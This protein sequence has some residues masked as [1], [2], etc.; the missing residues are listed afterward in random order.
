MIVS[1]RRKIAE[2]TFNGCLSIGQSLFKHGVSCAEKVSSGTG[3]LINPVG[4]QDCDTESVFR[5]VEGNRQALVRLDIKQDCSY[6]RWPRKSGGLCLEFLAMAMKKPKP[7]CV[8]VSQITEGGLDWTMAIPDDVVADLLTVQFVSGDE[9]L[10]IEVR[11]ALAGNNVLANGRVT[12][13]LRS[14]CGRCLAE[15]EFVVNRAFR[16]VFIEG[17]D[18]AADSAEEV[19]GETDDLNCTFFDGEEVD[20]LK[21]ACD[22][23]GLALPVNPLCRPDCRGLCPVCGADRN[24]ETCGCVMDD[25]D[26]R[27]AALKD[28]KLG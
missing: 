9:P 14:V 17:K 8:P 25:E 7:G 16:H 15:S 20:L 1:D 6:H 11:L 27:W 24:T 21:L 4:I 26:P 3:S 13:R 2:F 12:G 10:S 5:V 19:I 23:I 22:E 18:P 28:L